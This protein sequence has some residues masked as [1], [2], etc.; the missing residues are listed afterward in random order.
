MTRKVA[1]ACNLLPTPFVQRVS[2][3]VGPRTSVSLVAGL[4][5]P[6]CCQDLERRA[7]H[8]QEMGDRWFRGGDSGR[9]PRGGPSN[10]PLSTGGQGVSVPPRQGA[11]RGSA[12]LR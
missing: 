9:E 10:D 2:A 12:G 1:G 4:D 7:C 8:A 11:G 6:G 5:G 3:V